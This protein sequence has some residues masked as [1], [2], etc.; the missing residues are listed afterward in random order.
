MLL[1][2]YFA[3]AGYFTVAAMLAF[4]AFTGLAAW[5]VVTSRER[6]EELTLF[7]LVLTGLALGLVI[8]VDLVRVEDD[9]GRMN[10]LFKY[11]LEAWIL[12][13]LA[14]GYFLWR[15]WYDGRFRPFPLDWVRLIWIGVVTLLVLVSLIYTIL[16]TQAR[17]A[18]RFNPLPPTLDGAA[19]M[20]DAVHWEKEQPIELKYDLEAI[21]WLQEN[22]VGSPVVL[23]AHT[24]QYRWGGRMANYTGL[25][26]VLGWPWHQIQQRG[27]YSAEVHERARNVQQIY[28][29][30]D[31]ERAMR[32]M[33][34]YD[35]KYVVVGDLERIF[36]PGDGLGKF[37][38]MA[39]LGAA[40]KVFDNGH[41]A[42]YRLE[43]Q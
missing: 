16:G 12:L 43:A 4:L 13:A 11:Y 1:V 2:A 29:T 33:A 6:A 14:S 27:E 7:P 10:T 41:T 22:V 26:T 3:L 18:D 17:L 28:T 31:L 34:S 39:Q 25:P 32:L 36:Y 40:A 38:I 30:V 21:Q 9:I 8:G 42:I 37:D 23:E 5:D 35:V 24:E 19:F 15:M 20:S